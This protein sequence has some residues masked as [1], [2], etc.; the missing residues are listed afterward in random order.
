MFKKHM[1]PLTK[2]GQV[3]KHAGKGSQAT[4]L[5]NRGAMDA[6]ANAPDASMNDYSK[7][8]PVSQPAGNP[9]AGVDPNLAS[10]DSPGIGM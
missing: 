5:P 1:K 10:G 4:T 7:A 6:L 9:S 3:G 8:T 2:G